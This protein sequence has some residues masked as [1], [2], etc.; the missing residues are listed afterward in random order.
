MEIFEEI[1]V[2]SGPKH[3]AETFYKDTFLKMPY[4]ALVN[5]GYVIVCIFWLARLRYAKFRNQENMFFFKGMAILSGIYGFVQFMRII[6]QERFWGILDQWFT[7]PFFG[8]VVAWCVDL[9][10]GNIRYT[11]RVSVTSMAIIA[12][13][14]LSY[15]LALVHPHG[16]DIALGLH[17]AVCT[18]LCIKML[19][20]VAW[21]FKVLGPFLLALGACT[22]FVVLKLVDHEL[23]KRGEIFKI[24]SGHF[25]S[26]ICDF[27]QIHFILWYF[28]EYIKIV[29]SK[30]K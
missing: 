23:A 12:I 13:S 7:L 10:T 22:G 3:Y 6:T 1:E 9:L 4:N 11:K 19:K 29:A 20:N 14:T 8:M 21:N 30:N 24:V 5:F 16:F 15:L 2:G 18:Y 26:K 27:L 25:W 17:I 28:M